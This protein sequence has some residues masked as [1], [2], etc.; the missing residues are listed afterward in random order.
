[1]D[2]KELGK[3]IKEARIAKKMT[4]SQVVGNFIT[5]NMLS[6]IE[7][8][9]ATPSI[10]TLGYLSNVLQIPFSQLIPDQQDDAL[11]L[12]ETTKSFLAER[13]FEK[14]MEMEEKF[15]EIL[16]DEFAAIFSL[17]CLHLSKKYILSECYLEAMHFAQKSAEYAEQ[18]IYSNAAK[19][20]E[21]IMILTKAADKLKASQID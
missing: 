16:K 11:A 10:K 19:K 5:R 3:K 9:V 4:Q 21:G 18:G 2:S 8:G 12:L 14:V 17:A 15:P 1:M 13:E 6:Q 20:S 7:S